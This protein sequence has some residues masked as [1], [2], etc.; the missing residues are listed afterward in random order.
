MIHSFPSLRA[1]F[2]IRERQGG[3]LKGKWPNTTICGGKWLLEKRIWG[4][5]YPHEGTAGANHYQCVHKPL[6][7]HPRH[8]GWLHEYFPWLNSLHMTLLELTILRLQG[9][10]VAVSPGTTLHAA[11]LFRV[12]FSLQHCERVSPC[13]YHFTFLIPKCSLHLHFPKTAH[14]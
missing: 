3:Q 7:L 11:T 8:S 13:A 12:P 6:S 1:K 9:N 2:S 14:R 5:K 4:S 10:G